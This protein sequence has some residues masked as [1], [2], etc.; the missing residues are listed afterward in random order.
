MKKCDIGEEA[1]KTLY[2]HIGTPKTATTSLQ[3]FFYE[4]KEK[5][6][7]DGF[8]YPIYPYKYR[9]VSKARNA[10]F[11]FGHI[12]AKGQRDF[13]REKEIFNE[14]FADI[15]E[16]FE[17][18]D[19]VL[20]SDES[21]WTYGFSEEELDRCA[22]QKLKKEQEKGN[23]AIKVIVYL[24]R[25]DEF[26]FSV[27]NERVKIGHLDE[28]KMDWQELNEKHT[29]VHLDY[30]KMLEKIAGYVG[31]EN[32]IVH[33]FDKNHFMGSSIYDDFMG[34]IGLQ[35]SD[36]YWIPPRAS[37]VGFTKNNLEIKRVLNCIPDLKS[38]ENAMFRNV[39]LNNPMDKKD[40][41]AYSM[42][43][44]EEMEEF[45]ER[46][47][48]G[49]ERIA[50]EYMGK[51]GALFQYEYK[52]QEKWTPVNEE[53]TEDLILFMGQMI[54]QMQRQILEQDRK[55]ENLKDALKH[56]A[57]TVVNKGL[58]KMKSNKETNE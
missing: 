5:L 48:E 6:A 21:M 13:D 51:E 17:Q 56:P 16:A 19:N 24:R 42:F 14:A 53:M 36:E 41:P 50:K 11:L 44:K 58:E 57:R 2:I 28:R 25:Q 7:E 26:L 27:W 9:L 3:L 47:K 49:N 31:K 37:N 8:Y 1:V 10:H 33:V 32:I 22:W 4:N 29:N 35:C 38:Q 15:Y 40:N 12:Y 18:Y 23:F 39:L 52:A 55:I 46:Y 20:L 30:Y 43:S 45:W 34:V 54:L